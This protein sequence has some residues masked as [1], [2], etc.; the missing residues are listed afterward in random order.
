ML[1]TILQLFA[2]YTFVDDCDPTQGSERFLGLPYWFE[3]LP[4]QRDALGRCVPTFDWYQPE[5]LWGIG[6]AVIDILLRVVV[7]VAI[8]FVIWGGF[9]YMTSTGEPDKT[10]A[11]KDTILNAL[12][13]MAIAIAASVI[14]SFIGNSIR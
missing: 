12:I 2:Q 14:V 4:G 9:Q 10:K 3:Y 11:A 7:L 13:G 1:H 5:S 8:G 6:L